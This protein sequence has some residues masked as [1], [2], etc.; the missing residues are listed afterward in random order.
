MNNLSA[1]RLDWVDL[2]GEWYSVLKVLPGIESTRNYLKF[3]VTGR[4]SMKTLNLI[5]VACCSRSVS[6][7][8]D[9]AESVSTAELTSKI[10]STTK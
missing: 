3:H 1:T 5:I 4:N 2:E 10:F 6:V 9:R 8:Y 7:F